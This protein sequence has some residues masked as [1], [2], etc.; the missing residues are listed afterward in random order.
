[1][2]ASIRKG[3]GPVDSARFPVSSLILAVRNRDSTQAMEMVK[4]VRPECLLQKVE[5]AIASRKNHTGLGR[6]A[7]DTFSQP[8]SSRAMNM[9][10]SLKSS[11]VLRF[12]NAR[13]TTIPPM[14][15]AAIACA[16]AL[17]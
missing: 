8:P 17:R 2:A 15:K 1:M 11:A 4:P 3:V 7:L 5:L 6:F 12:A 16:L 10:P 13:A 9:H 14:H